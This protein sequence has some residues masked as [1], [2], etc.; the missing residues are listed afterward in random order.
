MKELDPAVFLAV[1]QEILGLFFWPLVAVIVL[2][3]VAFLYVLLR[4][5]RIAGARLLWSEVAGLLG[6][7]FALWFTFTITNSGFA[8]IG[9]PIDWVL[10]IVLAVLGGIGGIIIAYVGLGLLADRA[11]AR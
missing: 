5:R 9:G 11:P 2:G 8:D 10:L 1:L 7:V 3:G 4:E 6:A